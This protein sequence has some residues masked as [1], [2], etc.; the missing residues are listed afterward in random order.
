[1]TKVRRS[2]SHYGRKA[3]VAAESWPSIREKCT[4]ACQNLASLIA[5]TYS[6]STSRRKAQYLIKLFDNVAPQDFETFSQKRNHC[7]AQTEKQS[8]EGQKVT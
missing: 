7:H 4:S 6:D 8:E 1:M 5:Q 2:L 3:V